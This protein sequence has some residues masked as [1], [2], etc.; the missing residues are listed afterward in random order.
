MTWPLVTWMSRSP[1]LSTSN[2]LVPKP[3]GTKPEPSPAF[4]VTSSKR[5]SPQ[6]LVERVQL[7]GEVRDE[8]VR[9]PLPSTSRAVDAHAGLRLAVRVEADAG[10]VGDVDERA[11]AVVAIENSGPCRWRRRCR[12][13]RRDRSRRTRRR[14]PCR[15]GL[16][17]PACLRDV[18]ERAVAVVAKQP[19]GHA[20]E[21]RRIAVHPVARPCGGRST[22][23]R[24]CGSRGS[25]RRRDRD[26]RRGRSRRSR[27]WCSTPSAPPAT[28]AVAVTS[29]NV[30]S[31]LL[32]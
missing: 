3:S 16:A 24:R 2:S 28:P 20:V 9:Q 26:R 19:V 1:S 22:G 10:G 31:P 12:C 6:V 7:F 29:V 13:R 14:G 25:W 21:H 23:C 4:V 30:P 11:V 5:P 15:P 8:D 27:C 32:R 18:G 17:M